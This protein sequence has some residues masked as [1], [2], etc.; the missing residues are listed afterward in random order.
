MAGRLLTALRGYLD[1]STPGYLI[2]FVTPVCDCRCRMCFY[3]DAIENAKNRNVLTFEEVERIAKKWPG[4]HQINFS[5][6]EPFLRKDFP[7]IPALFYKHSG[8][9]GITCPTN[10]SHPEW[11]ERGVRRIC[12]TCPDAW[13]RIT[14]SIDAYGEKHDAI[15][16]K[17]GLFEKVVETNERLARLTEEFPNF[18]MGINTVFSFYNQNDAYELADFVYDHLKFTDYACGFVRGDVQDEEAKQVE[19]GAYEAF[20]TEL[21]RRRRA[22]GGTRGLTTRAFT[23]VNHTVLDYVMQTVRHHE[24]IMPCQAGRRM[25]VINDEGDVMPCEILNEKIRNGESKLDTPVIA[26]MRDMNYDIR[27]IL[28]SDRAHAAVTDIVQGKCH[29]TFECAWAVNVI[30][31]PRAWPRVFKNFIRV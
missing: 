5:G 12:E 19:T 29:C 27:K 15:R 20:Q 21:I 16:Q 18:S 11:I 22:K 17:K 1:R 4:L 10:S 24:Y 28:A 30:Y 8:T 9:R 13:I 3:L 14:Q 2:F 7:D 23:A 25:M 31:S 6:G 26:N